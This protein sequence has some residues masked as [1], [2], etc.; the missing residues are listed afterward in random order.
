MGANGA[1]SL[2]GTLTLATR[3]GLRG[4]EK[5]VAACAFGFGLSLILF[6]LSRHFWVSVALML[7]VGF[8]MFLQFAAMNTLV[9]AMVPDHL[10]GRVMAMWSMIF[11]GMVP[12][13]GFMAGALA[14][15]L[16]A[17][18]T[19]LLSGIGMIAASLQ[20]WLRLPSYRGEMRKLIVA[21]GMAGNSPLQQVPAMANASAGAQ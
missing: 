5:L 4:L 10:R 18:L 3:S 13:G 7:L 1:G 19:V 16:G 17:P 11:M 2:L 21:Q 8:C 6:G 9:Q 20:Y 14:Q 15:P 12:I